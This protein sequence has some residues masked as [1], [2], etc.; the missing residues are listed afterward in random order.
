M[1]VY[2]KEANEFLISNE[3]N[4]KRNLIENQLLKENKIL[5]E[6]IILPLVKSIQISKSNNP[7]KNLNLKNNSFNKLNINDNGSMINFYK[8]NQQGMKYT[9]NENIDISLNPLYNIEIISNPM[10]KKRE[11][12]Y[13]NKKKK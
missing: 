7:E 1:M 11:K 6:I 8:P 13:E 3:K 2:I 10:I 9:D 12:S 5:K 4:K